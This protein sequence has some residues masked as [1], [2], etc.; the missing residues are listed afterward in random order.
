MFGYS[1]FDGVIVLPPA[2]DETDLAGL[3]ELVPSLEKLRATAAHP[4]E[5]ESRV[6]D[7]PGGFLE[8][9]KDP[10]LMTRRRR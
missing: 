3:G 8:H 7:V 1:L 6:E 10:I 5:E 9:A 2:P 4:G